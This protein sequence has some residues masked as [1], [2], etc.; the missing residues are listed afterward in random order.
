[1]MR[2]TVIRDEFRGELL[3]LLVTRYSLLV[4]HYSLL[5]THYSL[6]ITHYSLLITH[7]SSV[8]ARR[9]IRTR[10]RRLPFRF[11]HHSLLLR[12]RTASRRSV[13]RGLDGRGCR[14]RARRSTRRGSRDPL[15]SRACTWR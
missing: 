8:R 1:M 6:L 9:D 5:I 13:S 12:R 11:D 15:A 14:R 7:Y 4:T 10:S 3:S 2:V